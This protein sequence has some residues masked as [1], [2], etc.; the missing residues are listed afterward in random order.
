MRWRVTANTS[1]LSPGENWPDASIDTDAEGEFWSTYFHPGD[2]SVITIEKLA[3]SIQDAFRKMPYSNFEI[4]AKGNKLLIRCTQEGLQSEAECLIVN[5]SN[6]SIRVLGVNAPIG[7]SR[8]KFVGASDRNRVRAILPIAVAEGMLPDEYISTKGSY[9]LSRKYEIYGNSIGFAPYLEKPVYDEEGEKLIDFVGSEIYRVVVLEN[10]NQEIQL[11]SDNKFTSYELFES[12]YGILSIMPVRDFDTDF[13]LSDY[14]KSYLPELVKYFGRYQSPLTVTGLSGSEVFFD[15]GITVSAPTYFPFIKI[16]PS[17]EAEYEI[18]NE[19]SQLFVTPGGT[20]SIISATG[21]SASFLSVGDTVILMPGDKILYAQDGELARFKGFVSLSSVVDDEEEA[22]FNQLENQWD[23]TRFY[24]HL[25]NSEYDRM[26][27]NSLK[28]L[29]LKSRVVPYILKWVSTQGKDIRENPYRFNYHRVFGSMNFS[30]S[31][32]IKDADPRFLT[33]EW[34][35]LDRIPEGFNVSKFYD[36]TFSYFYEKL[37]LKKYDLTSLKKDWFS[38]YFTVGYPTELHLENGKYVNTLIEPSERYSFF[39]FDPLTE[40]TY[41]LFRGQKIEI[42][43]IDEVTG[44]II[45]GSTKYDGY[46]FSVVLVEEEE[47]PYE[48]EDTLRFKTIVNE[49]FKFIAIL[50]VVK[51]TSYKYVSGS[52]GY[53]DLYTLENANQVAKFTYDPTYATGGLQTYDSLIPLDKKISNSINFGLYSSNSKLNSNANYYDNIPNSA[54]FDFNFEE[55]VVQLTTTGNYSFVVGFYD[56]GSFNFSFTLPTVQFVFDKNTINASTSNMFYKNSLVSVPSTVNLPYT[57]VGWNSVRCFHSSGGNKSLLGLR[58]RLSFFEI[59]KT[60]EGNSEIQNSEY[61]IVKENA[62]IQNVANFSLKM[63]KASSLTRIEDYV[64]SVDEDRPSQLFMEG[65][66]KSSSRRIIGTVLTAVKD[67]QTLYRYQGFYS[68]KFRDV[69]KFWAREDQKFTATSGIDFLLSNTHLGNEFT[70]FSTLQNQFFSKVADDEIL[71][72]PADSGYKSV[73]PLVNEISIDKKD[74]FAWNSSWDNLYY[75]KYTSTSEFT[76]VKGTSEMKELKS[77]FA[78][79]MM[80]IPK[81]YD[82]FEY[83]TKELE[84]PRGRGLITEQ[85]INFESL[86][87]RNLKNELCYLVQPDKITVQVNVYERLL[88]E[89]MGNSGDLRARS[90]FYEILNSVPGVFDANTIDLTVQEYLKKNILNLYEVSD[91]KFFVL[92]TG[93]SG[94]P[95][96]PIIEVVQVSGIDYTLPESNLVKRYKR[97]TDVRVVTIENNPLAFRIEFP[98]D[99]RF[100]T[101]VSIGTSVKRI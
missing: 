100:Y 70:G 15:A 65:F 61:I 25:L 89:M 38:E 43:E 39:N 52:L 16:L 58:E 36:S 54:F 88:R 17:G 6:S 74:D 66:G 22:R 93:D 55:E 18:F 34:P 83:Q 72:I 11:T 26:S 95:P 53:V 12:K 85:S 57:V 97:K 101:S 48:N 7:V 99:S 76:S 75:R 20:A 60:I 50:I 62:T 28:T 96:R 10:E 24:I 8:V 2:F 37:D 32:D 84:I 67:L 45:R 81:S 9:S 71:K 14:T 51:T 27:E 98:F 33:H 82:L 1:N 87:T 35:Y 59:S 78:S 47:N 86:F 73:Y 4:L 63:I 13:Y 64:P 90:E 68:P 29:V 30:P 92:E 79:K 49:K 5:Q 19:Q 80:K 42:R 21:S 40:S 41:T 44:E 94:K 77:Y 3:I 69:L 46:R 31:S 91:I 23:P 56:V